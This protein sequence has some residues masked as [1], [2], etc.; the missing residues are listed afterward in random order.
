M[1]TL[2]LNS[3]VFNG[4]QTGGVRGKPSS[5]VL[6]GGSDGARQPGRRNEVKERLGI[7]CHEVWAIIYS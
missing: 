2:I 6:L 1:N 4:K 7:S 3:L 5:A